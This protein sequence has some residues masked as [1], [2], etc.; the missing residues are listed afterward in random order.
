MQSTPSSSAKTKLPKD[1]TPKIPCKKMQINDEVT[2]PPAVK[3]TSSVCAQ[4]KPKMYKG[5][6]YGPIIENDGDKKRNC[7]P[8]DQGK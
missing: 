5:Y 2:P 7:W 8:N 3:S 6:K 1:N 4:G